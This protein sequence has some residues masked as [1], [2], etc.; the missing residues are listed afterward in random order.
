MTAPSSAVGRADDTDRPPPPRPAFDVHTWK[1]ILH[2]L[3]N[4]P[5][6]VVS[7]SELVAES[8]MGKF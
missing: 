4:L 1:E 3:L 7:V 6:T 8:N 5:V 2:L